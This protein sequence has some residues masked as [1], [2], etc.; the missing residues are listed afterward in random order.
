MSKEE[1]TVG[2]KLLITPWGY[3][4]YALLFS[5]PV[6]GFICAL[7]FAFKRDYQCRRN[8]ARYFLLCIILAVIIGIACA[9]IMHFALGINLADWAEQYRMTLKD[10]VT[11]F[12]RG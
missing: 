9:L 11:N 12:P 2:G 1:R 8:Y 4:G 7:V 3:L 10:A 6:I 5:I